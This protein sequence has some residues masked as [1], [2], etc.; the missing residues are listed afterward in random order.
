MYFCERHQKI[1]DILK[2]TGSASVN[3]LSEH[4]FVSP[5]TIR[6]DLSYLKEQNLIHRTFGGAALKTL[7]V[8]EI[9]FEL[10]DGED[11]AAKEIIAQKAAKYLADDMVIFL[12][13]SSTVFRLVPYIKNFNNITVVTNSPKV[14]LTLAEDGLSSHCTGGTLLSKSKAFVGEGAARFIKNFNADVFFFSCR[15]ITKEGFITD[16]SII[17]SEIRRVM[18]ANAD[19][20]VM[21]CSSVKIGKKYA[22]NVADTSEVD[23][24]ISE[25]D[26]SEM[27][28]K[29]DKGE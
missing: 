11:A 13:A 25:I 4:L 8:D 21:L 12:D 7:A 29:K 9:P 5:P 22:Y 15:G 3:K 6:R 28:S 18:M 20:S 10:R 26:T 2:E 24:I 1:L 17:E 14:C 16:S 27:F 23:E 19:K